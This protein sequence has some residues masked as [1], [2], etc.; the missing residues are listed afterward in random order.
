ML[1][2]KNEM[3]HDEK[4]KQTHMSKASLHQGSDNKEI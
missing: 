2:S 1:C 4:W 3:Q